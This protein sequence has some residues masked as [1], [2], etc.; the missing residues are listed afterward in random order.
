MT[1][2]DLRNILSEVSDQEMSIKELREI[3]FQIE[4]ENDMNGRSN[5]VNDS[6]IRR[7]TFR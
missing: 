2:S 1:Y 6:I 4:M 7:K 3:L 5:D